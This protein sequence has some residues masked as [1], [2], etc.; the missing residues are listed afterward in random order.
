LFPKPLASLS[1][2][3][4]SGYQTGSKQPVELGALTDVKSSSCSWNTEVMACARDQ[5]FVISRFVKS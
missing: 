1:D 5:D 4:A 2:V 3:V